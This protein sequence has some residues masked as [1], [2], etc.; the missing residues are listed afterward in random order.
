MLQANPGIPPLKKLHLVFI[1]IVE[2]ILTYGTHPIRAT[3]FD[4]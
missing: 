2:G 1:V 4:S 3:F